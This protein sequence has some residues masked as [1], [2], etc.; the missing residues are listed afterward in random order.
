M[1]LNF[2]KP[3]KLL[4]SSMCLLGSLQC[5]SKEP[6]ASQEQ[7]VSQHMAEKKLKDE[8]FLVEKDPTAHL[9]MLTD[10]SLKKD[11]KLKKWSS[12]EPGFDKLMVMFEEIPGQ[13]PYSLQMKR[14]MNPDPNMF[15]PIKGALSSS[16]IA[17]A[18]KRGIPVGFMT[19][20]RGYFPGENVT[21]RL[22]T[23]DPNVFREITICP[24]PLVLKK[25]SGEVLMRATLRSHPLE[26]T[27]YV[28]DICGIGK[29]EQF[30]FHSKSGSEN[31]QHTHKG[32]VFSTY[33]PGV[34]RSKGGT[35]I[36]KLVLEDGSSHKMEMPWGTELLR[37]ATRIEKSD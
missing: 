30:Q 6:E 26:L 24:R 4:I 33:M 34:V 3:L 32:P 12:V 27:C 1:Y 15:Y 36:I 22:T 31:M 29:D 5:A 19:T 14:L 9:D 13:P 23:N 10:E 11:S 35:A 17:G 28:L 37:C 2:T 21:I 18:K 25:S 7:S 8:G 20:P 16:E